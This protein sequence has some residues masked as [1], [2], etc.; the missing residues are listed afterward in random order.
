MTMLDDPS[1]TLRCN[2]HPT[3]EWPC[4]INQPAD[5]DL[6]D[7][8]NQRNL[9]LS[10]LYDFLEEDSIGQLG[11]WVAHVG[12]DLNAIRYPADLPAA[13]LAHYRHGRG[14]DVERA[15]NDLV[16]WPP[17]AEQIALPFVDE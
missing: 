14:Y 15:L 10:I 12:F 5:M 7:V 6:T 8:R 2:L 3:D 17:I 4:N 13:W 11:C 9:I 16:T 1:V